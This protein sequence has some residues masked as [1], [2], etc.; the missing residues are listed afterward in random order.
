VVTLVI[1]RQSLG[2]AD[3]LAIT[4]IVTVNA[5]TA[6][7][8]AAR[9]VYQAAGFTLDSEQPED[10]FGQRIMSQAWS[11]PLEGR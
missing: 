4:A 3:W 9:R 7:G 10:A 11:R 5:V 8:A 2:L 6:G 1:L